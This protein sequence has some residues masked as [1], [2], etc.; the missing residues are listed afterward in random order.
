QM[1]IS[2][3]SSRT[4]LDDSAAVNCTHCGKVFSLT[5]RKHHCRVCGLIFCAPCS[6]KTTQIAS[7][8]NP[9]RVCDNCFVEVQNR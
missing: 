2:K 6:S 4:W 5:V 7:H 1:D 9:V 8:K 3:H